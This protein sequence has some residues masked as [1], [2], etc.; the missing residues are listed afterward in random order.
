MFLAGLGAATT[1]MRATVGAINAAPGGPAFMAG[2]ADEVVRGGRR[3]RSPAPGRRGRPSCAPV[4]RRPRRP[5]RRS[6]A[7]WHS[8]LPVEAD[9]IVGDFVT[10]AE[11]NARRSAHAASLSAAYTASCRSTCNAGRSPARSIGR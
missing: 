5:R 6:T 8:G 2:I 3:G 1:L 7:T 4:S 10:E 9:A 11:R